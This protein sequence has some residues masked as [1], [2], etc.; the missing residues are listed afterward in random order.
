MDAILIMLIAMVVILAALCIVTYVAPD[1]LSLTRHTR[2]VAGAGQESDMPPKL[3]LEMFA[4]A[5]PDMVV[6]SLAEAK[7]KSRS[8]DAATLVV[9]DETCGAS[10]RQLRALLN[11]PVEGVFVLDDKARSDKED[12]RITH[13]PTHVALKRGI[14]WDMYTG[15]MAYVDIGVWRDAVVLGPKASD[16]FL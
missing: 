11:E 5:R 10:I 3:T 12:L 7:E 14:P 13:V 4:A 8:L 1:A 6:N 9:V 15:F 16:K 2:R